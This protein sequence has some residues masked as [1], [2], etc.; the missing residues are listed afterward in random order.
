M[1]EKQECKENM[2]IQR[3]QDCVSNTNSQGFACSVQLTNYEIMR[4]KDI[5]FPRATVCTL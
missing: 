3:L 4:H 1:G 2:M 5:N